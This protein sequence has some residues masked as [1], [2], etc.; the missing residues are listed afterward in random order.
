M[1][2]WLLASAAAASPEA[3]HALRDEFGGWANRATA[4]DRA[5]DYDR[6]CR[7]GWRPACAPE[8]WLDDAGRPDGARLAEVLAPFCERGDD[9]ACFAMHRFAAPHLSPGDLVRRCDDGFAPACTAAAGIEERQ[10]R[11]E[12]G[13]DGGDPLA[14]HHLAEYE[15]DRLVDACEGGDGAACA[16]LA[17][18]DAGGRRERLE[19]ACAGGFAEGCVAFAQ[20]IEVP[21]EVS[22]DRV[23]DP[24]DAA[25]RG[26]R[27]R[28]LVRAC[29]LGHAAGCTGAALDHHRGLGVPVDLAAAHDGFWDACQL[30]DGVACASLAEAILDRETEV[31]GITPRQ[32]FERGCELD[33]RRSCRQARHFDRRQ[34]F[35][36]RRLLKLGHT[37]VRPYLMVRPWLGGSGGLAATFRL[38]RVD[39]HTAR[40]RIDLIV[41]PGFWDFTL[42]ALDRRE[43]PENFSTFSA[44]WRQEPVAG[45]PWG[46]RAAVGSSV[47]QGAPIY[48]D[49]AIVAA[50]PG[51]P[52]EAFDLTTFVSRFD[53]E[54]TVD[55][56]PRLGVGLSLS[57]TTAW[58]SQAR[59]EPEGTVGRAVLTL[60]RRAPTPEP[61]PLRGASSELS[62]YAGTSTSLGAGHV[63]VWFADARSIPVVT[64]S[65]HRDVLALVSDVVVGLRRGDVPGWLAHHHPP[66]LSPTVGSWQLLRGQPAALM[67]GVLPVRARAGV[68]WWIAEYHGLQRHLG[69]Y[70][71]PFVEAGV[72]VPD[73]QEPARSSWR[74]DG[75]LSATIAWRR[76]HALHFE[77]LLISDLDNGGFTVAPSL[78]LQQ[79]LDPWR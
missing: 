12:R 27:H 21:V 18:R 76:R 52:A 11:L 44:Q 72:A 69:F 34:S 67:R 2:A 25:L 49:E 13:C 15:P 19:Q 56:N 46:A 57:S 30:G 42:G 4:A 73:L 7:Q 65:A 20:A 58:R 38:P 22:R 64:T 17:D 16:G 79:V 37:R 6:A 28:A 33:D 77:A 61:Q 14:C 23:P 68:R 59:T 29:D 8:A 47:W 9:L 45:R 36:A 39:E 63:G 32:L 62:V 48:D 50:V 54:R 26:E 35:V 40:R 70:V 74:S 55:R 10:A 66:R 71:T 78:V 24:A 51:E 75:G 60:F 41:E 1:I 53:L 5:A 3:L 43:T 31:F